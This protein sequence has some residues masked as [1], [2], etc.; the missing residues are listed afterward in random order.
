[1]EKEGACGKFTQSWEEFW[2]KLSESPKP[3]SQSRE[4]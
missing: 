4:G 2:G 3:E 1:V